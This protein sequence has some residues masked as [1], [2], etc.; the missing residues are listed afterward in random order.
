MRTE[1]RTC[2]HCGTQYPYYLSGVSPD[3]INDGKYCHSCWKKIKDALNEIPKKFTGYY[4][5]IK[6]IKFL[7]IDYEKDLE[8][9]KK[10]YIEEETK[11]KS[12]PYYLPSV[13]RVYARCIIN[14]DKLKE[15]STITEEYIYKNSTYHVCYQNN[16]PEE[17][18]I[19]AYGEYDLENKKFTGKQFIENELLMSK[20][21]FIHTNLDGIVI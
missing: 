5:D 3:G 8:P 19:Y 14:T 15:D 21:C 17:K 18:T 9:L 10:K 13:M 11:I 20:N 16:N 1:I 6:N 4:C 12:E 7:S 2:E